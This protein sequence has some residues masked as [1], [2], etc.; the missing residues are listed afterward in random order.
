MK[1]RERAY[2][3]KGQNMVMS[4]IPAGV[5]DGKHIPSFYM[6]VYPVTNFEYKQ[7]LM[8]ANVD[9]RNYPKYYNR[10]GYN[11]PSQPVVGVNYNNAEGYVKWAG[12]ELPTEAQWEYACL[13]GSDSLEYEG[14]IDLVAWHSGNSGGKLQRVGLKIPN[15]YGLY[16]MRGN[17][18]EIIKMGRGSVEMDMVMRGGGWDDFRYGARCAY[19]FRLGPD[20]RYGDVG[21][22]C[23]YNIPL[24]EHNNLMV[25]DEN[26]DCTEPPKKELTMADLRRDCLPDM[27][28]RE[29]HLRSLD[30]KRYMRD[31]V[32]ENDRDR[33]LRQRLT[34]IIKS[35]GGQVDS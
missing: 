23:V 19:R 20:G 18:Y 28:G 6:G 31:V 7:Y 8:K 24:S 30:K 9:F 2:E 1:N 27:Y 3:Y 22:R 4:K 29:D 21:F 14:D 13:A 34:K 12:L 10:S 35:I 26:T 15:A 16:D 25:S 11:E 5:L 32:K 33:D 17:I